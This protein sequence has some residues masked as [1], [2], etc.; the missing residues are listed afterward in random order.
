[1]SRLFVILAVCFA[2][3]LNRY[4]Q[5]H[6][7]LA[8]PPIQDSRSL[9]IQNGS[10]ADWKNG[11]PVGWDVE[12]GATN[13]GDTPV[14]K[15]RKGVDPSIELSGDINTKAWKMVRQIIAVQPQQSLRFSYSAKA[16]GIKREGKQFDNCYVG[17]YFKSPGGG[18]FAPKIWTVF[19]EK[20][21]S[22]SRVFRVPDKVKQIDVI[23]FLSV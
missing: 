6:S 4:G 22:E 18:K 1:M 20:L 11:Q 8:I 21:T 23:V 14:S 2:M 10:F 7:A 13:D 19:Q 17:V 15:I 9:G 12:I 5:S 3:L 16:A